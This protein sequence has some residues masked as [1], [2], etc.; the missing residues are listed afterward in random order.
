MVTCTYLFINP[1][2]TQPPKVPLWK[3]KRMHIL[4]ISRKFELMEFFLMAIEI[5][6]GYCTIP[7]PTTSM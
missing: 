6:F 4:N 7:Q 3:E 5:L 2:S 1:V